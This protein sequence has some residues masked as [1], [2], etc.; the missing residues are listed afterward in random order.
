MGYKQL[1]VQLKPVHDWKLQVI[2]EVD[3]SFGKEYVMAR[4]A[5]L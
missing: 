3:E 1:L 2:I 5:V 4:L